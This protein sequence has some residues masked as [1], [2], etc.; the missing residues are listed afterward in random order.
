MTLCSSLSY[1]FSVL[2]LIL[3]AAF[4]G[5]GAPRHSGSDGSGQDGDDLIVGADGSDGTGSSGGLCS[6]KGSCTC[7]RLALL[8]TLDSEAVDK[9]SSAFVEWLNGS[10]D[11]TAEV[12]LFD[13]KPTIDAAFLESY[14]ILIVA[15]VNTWTF[16]E[17]EKA[18]VA[19]WVQ[20]VGGGL[21]TLTGFSSEQSEPAATSQLLGFSGISYGKNKVAEHG[22]GLPIYYR[23]GAENL[24]NCLVRNGVTS[25]DAVITTPIA[26][27][28]ESGVSESL[29][30]NLNYVGAFIGWEVVVPAEATVIATDPT[31]MKPIAAAREMGKGRVVAFGDEWIVFANQWIAAGTPT[32]MQMDQHNP[33]WVP[34]EESPTGTAFFHSVSS[35]YQTKQFWYNAVSW[36]APARECVF[37]VNDDDVIIK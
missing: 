3:G 5:C 21:L 34:V 12:T 8:G 28:S 33:C 9:D 1:R 35:L 17:S 15:N 37:V 32:N 24:R 13:Q 18:A 6:D 25:N 30:S 36:L 14:D 26:F 7:V 22:E 29:A 27:A 4:V 11:E 2:A 23:G 16:S 10:S 19:T 20:E 31:T